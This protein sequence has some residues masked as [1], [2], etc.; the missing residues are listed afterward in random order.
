MSINIHQIFKSRKNVLDIFEEQG[1]N[2]D[3]YKMFSYNELSVMYEHDGLDMLIEPKDNNTNSPTT[4]VNESN[5][6]V[7]T[8]PAPVIAP[9]TKTNKIYIKYFIKKKFRS[10]NIQEMV[11]NLFV[12][13]EKLTKHDTLYIIILDEPNDT[14]RDQLKHIW[15]KDEIFIVVQN[16]KRLQFN[17]MELLQ[18]PKQRII[19]PDEKTQLLKKFNIKDL[20][21]LPEISRFDPV[22]QV[23][24]LRPG[25]I[26]I[27]LRPSK[28]SITIEWYRLCI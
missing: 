24:C 10:A 14:I 19:T 11:D 16:V 7:T 1:Y 27:S 26:S 5:Q 28:T 17:I 9:I 18:V 6:P 22:A 12:T 13:E 20:S 21:E 2:V 23:L 3:M 25:M 15:E 4:A 8:N